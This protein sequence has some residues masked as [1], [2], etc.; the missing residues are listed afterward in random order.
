MFNFKISKNINTDKIQKQYINEYLGEIKSY[1]LLKIVP[2]IRIWQHSK[3]K[4]SI[5]C[6]RG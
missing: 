1:I 3:L 4:L 2:D 5:S 6:T